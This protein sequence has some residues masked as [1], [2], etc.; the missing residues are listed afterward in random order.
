MPKGVTFE[1]NNGPVT[2]INENSVPR[3]SILGKLIEI[4][5]TGNSDRLDLDRIPAEIE[6]KVEFN[7]L[8]KYKWLVDEFIGS[9]LLIDDSILELN[10]TILNGSTKLK[11]QMKLFYLKSLAKFSIVT[12][13]FDLEMFIY[14][15]DDVVHEVIHL[16][17]KFVK[18]SSDLKSGYFE[19][20]I[21]NG[22][23]LI[24]SY[25]IIECIVLENPNDY[26]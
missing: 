26:D 17:T 22:V 15:S 10:R 12:K 25:S 11:R 16:V 1:V 20:D 4:I 5:A 2:V 19:E 9:S 14:H 18:S 8:I 24:V 7:N 23:A 3:A 13:P 21:E 6:H